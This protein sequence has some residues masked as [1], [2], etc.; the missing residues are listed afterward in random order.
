MAPLVA[1]LI[2]SI[3]ALIGAMCGFIVSLLIFGEG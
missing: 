1:V 2:F 3:I